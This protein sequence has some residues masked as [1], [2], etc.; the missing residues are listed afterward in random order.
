[1]INYTSIDVTKLLI[2][3]VA[4]VDT[5]LN[6]NSNILQSILKTSDLKF[7]L[8]GDRHFF[9][10]LIIILSVHNGMT[11]LAV[12]YDTREKLTFPFIKYR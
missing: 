6:I 9:K 3:F 4:I 2:I 12:I 7:K 10:H 8:E 1:L 11:G 5:K